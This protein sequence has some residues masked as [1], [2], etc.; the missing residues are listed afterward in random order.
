VTERITLAENG[1]YTRTVGNGKTL[2]GNAGMLKLLYGEQVE[3]VTDD[4]VRKRF[5][6][7]KEIV[8]RK[9]GD[10]REIIGAII[11]QGKKGDMLLD[12]VA[13]NLGNGKFALHNLEDK[14]NVHQRK[15]N[16]WQALQVKE[17][18]T[19]TEVASK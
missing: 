9:L 18:K 12:V 14:T 4:E 10:G 11:A 16:R 1:D 13:V 3:T 19:A 6:A 17:A 8:K 2:H 5:E 15:A 7:Q